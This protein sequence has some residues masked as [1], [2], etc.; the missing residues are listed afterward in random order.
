MSGRRPPP[1]EPHLPHLLVGY[2][3]QPL[4][5]PPTYLLRAPNSAHPARNAPPNLAAIKPIERDGF[6]LLLGAASA[7]NGIPAAQ[8]LAQGHCCSNT[9][10]LARKNCSVCTL[11]T[12]TRAQLGVAT[13]ESR[14]HA[15][16]PAVR[17]NPA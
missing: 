9:R 2:R 17:S 12:M 10:C 15:D 7:H 4:L 16:R 6:N 13:V 1:A 8:H 3:I 14:F 11:A 5:S